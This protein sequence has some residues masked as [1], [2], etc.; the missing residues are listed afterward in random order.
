MPSQ[1]APTSL[2]QFSHTL[3]ENHTWGS[4]AIIR[5]HWKHWGQDA[6]NFAH[7]A[8]TFSLTVAET[9]EEISYL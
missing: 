7:F 1:L 6:E 8:P 3:S 2:H 5:E 9:W 4:D